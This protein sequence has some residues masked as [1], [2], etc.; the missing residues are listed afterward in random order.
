MAKENECG[1]IWRK[2]N[3]RGEFLSISLDMPKLLDMTGG[4][5]TKVNCYAFPVDGVTNPNAPDYRIN[6]YM[7]G[8]GKATRP[9]TA[10]PAPKPLLDDDGDIPF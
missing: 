7:K 6:F 9:V 10:E 3:E 2:T 8:V 5:I 1:A 4:E